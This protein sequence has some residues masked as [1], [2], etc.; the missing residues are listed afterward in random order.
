MAY[1]VW[2]R[3]MADKDDIREGKDYGLGIPQQNRAFYLKG[4]G[5]LDWGMQNRLARIF[6]PA[7]GRTVMLAF[8]H[9]YFQGPTGGV[10]RT[11]R[12][13]VPRRPYARVPTGTRG[14]ARSVTPAR[15][16]TPA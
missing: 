15:A 8:G 6:N 2:W 11:G 5:A 4:A 7:S 9:G 14:A 3:D 16:T 13:A 1:M 10:E 12:T